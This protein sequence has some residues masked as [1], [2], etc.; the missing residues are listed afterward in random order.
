MHKWSLDP[1]VLRNGATAGVLGFL[2]LIGFYT[3]LATGIMGIVAPI[4]SLSA[5]VPVVIGLVQ[6]ERPSSIQFLGIAVGTSK[7][8]LNRARRLLTERLALENP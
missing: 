6:G 7:A 3:A 5:V 4:S 2:G 1:I 8:Q